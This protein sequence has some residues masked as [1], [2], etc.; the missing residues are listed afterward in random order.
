MSLNVVSFNA[1][2]LLPCPLEIVFTYCQFAAANMLWNK[3][4]LCF[5]Q[6]NEEIF[7]GQFRVVAYQLAMTH[8]QYALANFSQLAK[9]CAVSCVCYHARCLRLYVP[10]C[11][12]SFG[13]NLFHQ[14]NALNFSDGTAGPTPSEHVTCECVE[15]SIESHSLHQQMELSWNCSCY[16]M[17]LSENFEDIS[18]MLA[19]KL[20]YWPR[21]QQVD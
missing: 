10:S 21:K 15:L 6:N 18:P 17:N 7:L 1:R 14:V 16:N 20:L 5:N 11:C 8:L 9:N 3:V 13:W 4:G 19:L 12:T 2:H